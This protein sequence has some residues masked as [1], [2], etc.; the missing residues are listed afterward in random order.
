MSKHH[1]YN[2]YSKPN[3]QPVE[4]TPEKEEEVV[5]T[6]EETTE[7]EVVETV[8]ESAVEET[9]EETPVSATGIVSDCNKLNV[10]KSPT[11]LAEVLCVIDK[12]SKVEIDEAESTA[13]FYKVCTASGVEG[14]CMKKFITVEQ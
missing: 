9:V 7:E 10:R 1:N 8:E 12:N 3:N 14:Y 6:V 5:E 13:E 11:P 4:P 2:N